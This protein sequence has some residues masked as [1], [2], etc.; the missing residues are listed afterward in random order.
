MVLFYKHISGYLEAGVGVKQV[1]IVT[2]ELIRDKLFWEGKMTLIHCGLFPVGRKSEPWVIAPDVISTLGC[3][4]R[5]FLN[6]VH[7]L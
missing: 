6:K 3:V 4:R 7:K 5:N 1:Q 2:F